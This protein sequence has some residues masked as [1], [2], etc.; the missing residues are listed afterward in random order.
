MSTKRSGPFF[1]SGR[2]RRALDDLDHDIRNH[3]DAET[4]DNIE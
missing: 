3:I 1:G 2:R 4:Q